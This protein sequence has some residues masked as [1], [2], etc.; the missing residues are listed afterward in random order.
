M[1]YLEIF[2]S[3]VFNKFRLDSG[4]ELYKKSGGKLGRKIGYRKSKEQK[5][6]QYA[7]VTKLLKRW[8]PVR[9]IPKIESVGISTVM[10]LKKEFC[11]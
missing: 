4:R 2:R 11:E 9:N 5:L 8:Y 1:E 7:G 6:E 3:F 10:R